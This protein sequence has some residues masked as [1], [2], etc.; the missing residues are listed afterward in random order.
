MNK[1]TVENKSSYFVLELVIDQWKNTN[2]Y[3]TNLENKADLVLAS[4][5]VVDTCYKFMGD[6]IILYLFKSNN[7]KRKGQL[8]KYCQSFLPEDVKYNIE[9]INY[10]SFNVYLQSAKKNTNYKLEQQPDYLN[11]KNDSY[12]GKDLKRFENAKD[13]YPWQKQ[14]YDSIF[15]DIDGDT[16]IKEPDPR[17]IVSLIDIK[18]NSGKSSFFKW[19]SYKYPK[20]IGRI[21][22]GSASQLRSSVVNIGS[23]PLYIVDLARSKSK[24]D[25]PEDLLSVLEDL[26]SGFVANAMYGSGKTLLMEPPHII[27]SSN[28]A[29]N[30][31]LLS[32]DRWEIFEIK[33]KKL[34]R[35]DIRN[36]TRL[37]KV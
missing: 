35:I 5:T 24:N 15:L 20:H 6:S 34:E 9:G 31:E 36:R 29:F 30:Y 32:E 33:D 21:G 10:D 3:K 23:K 4:M 8:A 22:Y 16:H 18:G 7:R 11:D 19:L 13:W 25:H 14:I 2:E 17:H 12:E 1:P 27:V 26:K 37:K 28:Y